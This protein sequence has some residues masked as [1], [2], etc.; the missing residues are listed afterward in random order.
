MNAVEEIPLNEIGYTRPP[1]KE[2]N[3]QESD[4]EAYSLVWTLVP[5]ESSNWLVS[6]KGSVRIEE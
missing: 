3:F 6:V 5:F 2:S 1:K 4:E